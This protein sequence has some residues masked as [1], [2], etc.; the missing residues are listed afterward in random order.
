MKTKNKIQQPQKKNIIAL[1]SDFGTEDH[2]VAAMKGRILSIDP[3]AVI[4]DITHAVEPH[5]VRQGEYLLWS[6]YRAFPPGTI[7][8]CVVDP[9]VGTDRNIL[10]LQTPQY[11]FL[12]PENGLSNVIVNEE[13]KLEAFRVDFRKSGSYLPFPIS[14]TFHGRD[15]F[16]PLAA[17]LSLGVSI[18]EFGERIELSPAVSLFA[19]VRDDVVKPNIVHIDHF[20][21]IITNIR[22]PSQEEAQKAIKAIGIGHNLV[23]RW[24]PTYAEAPEN[25]PCLLVGSSGLVEISIKNKKAAAILSVGLDTLLKMYWQ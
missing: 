5:N 9:G 15:V 21:N 20:G 12:L 16:A 18:K 23:S 10:A 14:T 22:I 6:A 25:T 4:A 7:F 19:R 3:S 24:S 2:Y 1:M 13:P 11:C 17:H 8:V